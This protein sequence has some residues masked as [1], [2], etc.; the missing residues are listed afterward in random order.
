[1]NQKHSLILKIFFLSIFLSGCSSGNN[2]SSIKAQI[3]SKNCNGGCWIGIEPEISTKNQTLDILVKQYGSENV[4]VENGYDESWMINWNS[5]DVESPH[6]G[7]VEGHQDKVL[8]IWI[9]FPEE[10]LKVQGLLEDMGNPY[11]V[12][13]VLSSI[14]ESNEVTC[15]GASLLYPQYGTEF[16]LS[17]TSES[18]GVSG[19]QFVNGLHIMPPWKL[20][21][22]PWTDS[23]YDQWDGYHEYCPKTLSQ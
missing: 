19:D 18:V 1:V 5:N 11:S 4:S 10:N 20:E 22:R 3:I 12:K 23:F 17:Q 8:W 9:F 2:A 6:H 16:Y 13:T 7:T 15:A 14:K 21:E